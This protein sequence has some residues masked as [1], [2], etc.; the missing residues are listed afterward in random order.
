VSTRRLA[1]VTSPDQCKN[2]FNNIKGLAFHN[3][4]R[5]NL[6]NL[7]PTQLDIIIRQVE[8]AELDEMWCFV[9]SKKQQRWLWHCQLIENRA[10]TPFPGGN[11]RVRE[12]RKYR[13]SGKHKT[14]YSP[15][16]TA[17]MYHFS[18]EVD[19]AL[20][21]HGEAEQARQV[22]EAYARHEAAARAE[23]EARLAAVEAQLRTLRE[24]GSGD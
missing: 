6:K 14:T 21:S 24:Q 10:Q 5:W 15:L 12:R 22:A 17:Q 1:D 7:D 23:V 9:G 8:D 20:L 16:F 18:H 11:V 2:N 3:E 19:N 13:G 4:I